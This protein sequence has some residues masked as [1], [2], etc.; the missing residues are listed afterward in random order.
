MADAYPVGSDVG[1]P[2]FP[3]TGKAVARLSDRT[4]DHR[5]LPENPAIA[6]LKRANDRSLAVPGFR[7]AALAHG[8]RRCNESEL[9]LRNW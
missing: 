2:A 7:V 1:V 5:Q 6:K 9:G 8:C 4:V 3:G